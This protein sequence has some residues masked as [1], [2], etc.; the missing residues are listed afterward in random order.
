MENDTHLQG[1]V[2]LLLAE[3]SNELV[4]F[5]QWHLSEVDLLLATDGDDVLDDLVGQL[6]HLLA[7]LWIWALVLTATI[8][9]RSQLEATRNALW[10]TVALAVL[11][12]HEGHLRD[13]VC[14]GKL[15]GVHQLLESAIGCQDDGAHKVVAPAIGDVLENA[16]DEVSRRVLA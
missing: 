5:L 9:V 2:I 10:P 7:K 11:G 8:E 15:V 3:Q 14:V 16:H 13:I 12:I 6:Q 1:V 4:Q